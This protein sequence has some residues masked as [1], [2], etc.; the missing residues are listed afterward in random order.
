[1]ADPEGPKAAGLFE[2][3]VIVDRMPGHEALNR[4][5]KHVIAARR[6]QHRGLDISNIGGWHSDIDMLRWGGAP[7]LRL[8]ERIIATADAFTTDIKS[9]GA[10]R[11]RWLPEMWAN[12]SPPGASNSLH[13]H[14]GC[15]WS[16]VYYVDDGYGGSPD[17]ALGGELVLF[18]PRMPAIRMNSPD[19]RFRR[20]GGTPDHHESLMRPAS[21]RIVIFPAW[22]SHSVR[23][24]RGTGTRISIAVNLSAAPVSSP[25]AP[26]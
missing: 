15:F 4:E 23:P 21:G 3:P 13:A 6:A 18:D 1:V 16:A 7:A 11:F 17:R 14:P 12:V 25:A 22:L 10:P 2:T 8:I 9:G 5:L 24:Y 20:P 19:L 26:Q